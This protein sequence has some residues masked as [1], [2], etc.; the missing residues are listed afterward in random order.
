MCVWFLKVD[1]DL[2]CESRRTTKSA[3]SIHHPPRGSGFLVGILVP[4]TVSG[5]QSSRPKTGSGVSVYGPEEGRRLGG[6]W[7]KG[8]T[9]PLVV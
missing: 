7:G 6:G 3:F 4:F 1:L 2:G 8:P 5:P 9:E